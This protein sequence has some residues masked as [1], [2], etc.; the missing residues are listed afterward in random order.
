MALPPEWRGEVFRSPA[1][2]T[3]ELHLTLEGLLEYQ[4]RKCR[5]D[6]H[7]RSV[8][9]MKSELCCGFS[10]QAVLI[11]GQGLWNAFEL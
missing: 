9:G 5:I 1:L 3:R 11:W 8:S 10:V 2:I 7:R 4:R 6:L